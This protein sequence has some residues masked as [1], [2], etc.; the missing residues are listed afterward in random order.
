MTEAS[1]TSYA[2]A[3]S[4]YHDE[5]E[6]YELVAVAMR[7]W[8]ASP[9]PA[10]LL[11]GNVVSSRRVHHDEFQSRRVPSTHTRK[12]SSSVR[13]LVV[14]LSICSSEIYFSTYSVFE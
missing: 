5:E 11:A 3:S 9:S 4:S 2:E 8:L 6:A 7:R 12:W 14:L 10:L 13:H 1:T